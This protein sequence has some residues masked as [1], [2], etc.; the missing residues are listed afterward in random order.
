MMD[1][2][3]KAHAK[4]LEHKK[5]RDTEYQLWI[6]HEFDGWFLRDFCDSVEDAQATY[7]LN[8]PSGQT[9]YR[10]VAVQVCR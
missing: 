5:Q 4:Y 1:A 10:I 2:N 6:F 9:S 7:R 8:F 3:D